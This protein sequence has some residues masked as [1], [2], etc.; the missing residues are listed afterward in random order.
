M[1]TTTTKGELLATRK[2]FDGKTVGLWSDGVVT[3]GAFHTH[4]KGCGAA[5]TPESLRLNIEAGWLL[6][7]EASLYDASELPAAVKA[8]RRAVRVMPGMPIT[9]FREVMAGKKLVAC[10]SP[11]G[12]VSVFK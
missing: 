7:G 11:R 9:Y 10:N 1:K 2:T 6:L 8:A 3:V 12:G 4:V 5:S